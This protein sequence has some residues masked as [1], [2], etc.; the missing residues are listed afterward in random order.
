MLEG[1]ANGSSGGAVVTGP[2]PDA[3]GAGRD[4][5]HDDPD[6]CCR[7]RVRV[8]ERTALVRLANPDILMDTDARRMEER[9]GRLVRD[10]GHERL[11]LNLAG[12]RHMPGAS[13]GTLATLG[14]EVG[15]RGG[16]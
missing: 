13:L 3:S 1:I 14:E 8:I 6:G 4:G 15:R 7:L 9:L 10:D 5:R 2:V 11:L 16:W 12:V